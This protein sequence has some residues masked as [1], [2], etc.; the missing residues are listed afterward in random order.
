MATNNQLNQLSVFF[1]APSPEKTLA[2]IN[3]ILEK[4]GNSID[5]IHRLV[6]PFLYTTLTGVILQSALFPP[7]EPTEYADIE[8]KLA[9]IGSMPGVDAVL[10]TFNLQTRERLIQG[11]IRVDSKQNI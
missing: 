3:T 5:G 9:S 10:T 8:D 7:I 2:A 6:E 11:K 1:S 4:A